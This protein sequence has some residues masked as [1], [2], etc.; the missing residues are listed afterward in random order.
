MSPR[1]SLWLVAVAL[2]LGAAVFF[3]DQPVEDEFQAEKGRVF[4]G[5]TADPGEVSSISLTTGDGARVRVERRGG[6]WWVVEPVE[7]PAREDLLDSLA[8]ALV[9]VESA[10]VI[11]SP[12]EPEVYGLGEDASEV[13]FVLDGNRHRMRRPQLR[14]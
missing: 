1:T 9:R 14:M 3:F 8:Q 7:A 12:Q 5:L 13:G 6:R 2:V 4:A 10:A 11:E